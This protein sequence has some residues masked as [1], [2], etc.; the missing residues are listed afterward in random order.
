MAHEAWTFSIVQG[1]LDI[2][3]NISFIQGTGS[4]GVIKSVIQEQGPHSE[5]TAR[6]IKEATS[7]DLQR[8][9]PKQ[10]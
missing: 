7:R 3:D 8:T 5:S 6:E 4:L 9:I 2:E 1:D 10:G